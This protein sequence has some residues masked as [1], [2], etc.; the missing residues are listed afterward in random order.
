MI[1]SIHFWAESSDKTARACMGLSYDLFTGA[2]QPVFCHLNIDVGTRINEFVEPGTVSPELE[3]D[4]SAYGF[5]IADAAKADTW[6][7]QYVEEVAA[8]YDVSD[9]NPRNWRPG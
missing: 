2:L 1:T 8:W 7:R 4:V 9:I 6:L 5:D 3:R